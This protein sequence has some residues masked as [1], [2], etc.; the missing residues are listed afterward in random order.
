[1]VPITEIGEYVALVADQ[2][3]EPQPTLADILS[4]IAAIAADAAKTRADVAAMKARQIESQVTAMQQAADV[5]VLRDSYSKMHGAV[6]SG[7]DT[8][9]RDLERLRTDETAHTEQVRGDI[10]GVKAD[11]AFVEGYV[12]DMHE[13]VRRHIVDPNS[14][15]DAA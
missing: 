8:V 7:F 2:T 11:T 6:L 14:H 10:A 13:A 9:R 4:A 1:M 5:T 3:P 15:R 12:N